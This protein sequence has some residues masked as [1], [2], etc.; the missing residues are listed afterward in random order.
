MIYALLVCAMLFQAATQAALKPAIEND[1]VTVWDV[2]DSAPT[3]QTD[4]VV[5]SLSGNATWVPRGALQKIDGRSMIIDLKEHPSPAYKNTT[6]YPLAFPRP[7][8]KKIL[9]NERV[10]V[11][12]YTWTPDVAT[13]MHFHDKDV[14]VYYFDDGDLQSTTPSGEKTVNS[15]KPGMIRFN[16]RDRSHTETLIRGKQHGIMTELK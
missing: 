9:E 1:R 13:P 6:P 16:L 14:V 12:D 15:Y 2:T 8:S 11:W 3:Q 10:I 7:G 4:A 5:V